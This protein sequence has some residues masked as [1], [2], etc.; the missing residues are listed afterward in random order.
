MNCKSTTLFQFP[1]EITI[2]NE[3]LKTGTINQLVGFENCSEDGLGE[4]F[5]FILSNGTRSAQ[6][7]EGYTY[8]DHMMPADAHNKIRSVT[9]YHDEKGING[10]KFFDKDGAL[11]WDVG[12][13][14]WSEKIKE[15]VVLGEN[16]VIVGVSAK[17]FGDW[18][19]KYT[20]F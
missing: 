4:I 8:Y 6:R 9:I 16:E 15:T 1:D 13:T 7:D 12:Y 11:L 14:T 5:N 20:D 10:F 3:C 17:L 2:L 19:S 18:Q